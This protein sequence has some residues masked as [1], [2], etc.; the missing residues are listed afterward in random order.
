MLSRILVPVRG[1]GMGEVVLSHAAAL[2]H[3]HSAH[4]V[5]AHCRP[6]PEEML[7]YSKA[8]P[9]FARRTLLEQGSSGESRKRFAVGQHLF[10]LGP[11][12]C[13]DD[14][15]AVTMGECGSVG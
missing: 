5:V 4:I 7:P 1:D 9:A 15:C 11:A 12:M 14:M 8:L 13:D 10:G 6:Q 3:R 2:A